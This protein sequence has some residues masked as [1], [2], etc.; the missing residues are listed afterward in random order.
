MDIKLSDEQVKAA[1]AGA[2]ASLMTGEQ[3][4]ELIQKAIASLLTSKDNRSP[5]RTVMQSHF[6]SAISEW[7][8]SAVKEL[9]QNDEAMKTRIQ[10]VVT[11]AANRALVGE[12]REKLINTLAD[13]IVAAFAPPSRY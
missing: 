12:G 9:L 1:V 3:R 6:E 7:A 8:R 2:V 11:E 5:Y 4:A 13:G 10:E